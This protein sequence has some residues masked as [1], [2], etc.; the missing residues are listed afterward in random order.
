MSE[1][2][3]QGSPDSGSRPSF[4]PR[5]GKL[6]RLRHRHRTVMV[7]QGAITIGRRVSC[8]IVLTDPKVSR[9]HARV[10]VGEHSAA[11][12]D[13][14][15]INGVFVNKTRV[16]G[17][18]RLSAGDQIGIGQE[19]IEV[20]GFADAGPRFEAEAEE[21]S[22]GRQAVIPE[23]MDEDDNPIPTMVVTPKK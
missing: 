2:K 15:S 14:A 20:L 11:V 4:L 12:E 9:E 1:R 19:L 21:T 13:L 23:L 18:H 10:I 5:G 3:G 7:G 6:F 8:D 16:R 17:M 22:I